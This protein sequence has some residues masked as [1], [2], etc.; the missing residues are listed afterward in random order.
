MKP[1]P[2]SHALG[3][4]IQGA[5]FP[6]LPVAPQGPGEWPDMNAGWN[7]GIT[8]VMN[9]ERLKYGNNSS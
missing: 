6:L 3:R 4:A 5:A 1:F 2:G 7:S 8:M 9:L